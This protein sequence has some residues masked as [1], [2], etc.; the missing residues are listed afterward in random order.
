MIARAVTVLVLAAWFAFAAIFLLRKKPAGVTEVKR[1]SVARLGI[2]LQGIAF[3]LVWGFGRRHWWTLTASTVGEL[4]LAIVA[5]AL[6]WGSCWW[7]LRSVQTLGKQWTVQ[8]RLIHE[9]ELITTGPFGI[10]RNPI[11]LGMFGMLLATGLA[12]SRWWAL[13]CA[14]VVFLVGNQIRIRAEE[15]LLREAF[16]PK[17][18]D[19]ARRVPA[20]LPRRL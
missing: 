15:R 20:F 7:C 8:A 12:F 11:Y 14:V 4:A 5:V 16:G 3:G 9:H 2:V 17:F 13:L 6:A 18:E 1:A 19:Y 10:V